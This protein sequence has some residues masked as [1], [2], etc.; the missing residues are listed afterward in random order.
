MP[1]APVK[2]FVCA[3]VSFDAFEEPLESMILGF[4]SSPGTP[5]ASVSVS[6]EPLWSSDTVRTH[7]DRKLAQMIKQASD[8]ELRGSRTFELRGRLAIELRFAWRH[9]SGMVEQTMVLV[10]PAP[11]ALRMVTVFNLT[12][13]EADLESRRAAFWHLLQSARFGEDLASAPALPFLAPSLPP[14]RRDLPAEPPRIPM[15]PMPG[16]DRRL[17]DR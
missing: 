12:A 10:E 13:P 17:G 7:A 3:N 15:I 5:A 6:R 4:Q 11:G 14:P 2:R 8:F 9:P 16:H 1:A